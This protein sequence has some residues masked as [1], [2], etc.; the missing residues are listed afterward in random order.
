MSAPENSVSV[1]YDVSS[2]SDLS[3]I[4]VFVGRRA[5]ASIAAQVPHEIDGQAE[6]AAWL[7]FEL[8]CSMFPRLKHLYH[9]ANKNRVRK[10]N[11][12]RIE[13]KFFCLLEQERRK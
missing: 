11:A 2:G 5:I 4:C 10:K 8:A 7:L 1:G 9:H 12:R 3:A 13:Q 6:S